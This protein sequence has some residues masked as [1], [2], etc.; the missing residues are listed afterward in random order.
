MTNHWNDLANSD[1]VMIVGCNP[2]ENH[3][4]SFK[5][6]TQVQDKG[7]KLIVVDPRFTRSAAKADLFVRLRPGTDVALFA[8][9]I[10][11]VLANELYFKDY[12]TNYTNAAFPGPGG[13]FL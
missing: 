2:A 4:I 7:G 6:I 11:Y 9:L 10:N 3:P 13:F 8:G 12:L 1:C 5:Y